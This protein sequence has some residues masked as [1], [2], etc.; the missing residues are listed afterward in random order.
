MIDLAPTTPPPAKHGQRS[1]W[2]PGWIPTRGLISAKL[3]D[4]RR[5][6]GLMLAA[7]LM[8]VA[9]PFLIF[10]I[11][12]VLHLVDPK[13]FGPGGDP[14]LFS[15]LTDLMAEFGFLFAA[16]LGTA[17]G[18]TD[19]SD[20]VFRQL[21]ITGRSRLA[22]YLARIPAGLVIVVPLVAVAFS[23]MCLVTR[24]ASP[25]PPT[26]VSVNG[27]SIPLHL[28]AAGFRAWLVEHPEAAGGA[29]GPGGP[30]TS[31][32]QVKAEIGIPT[33]YSTYT[34]QELAQTPLA[35]NEM[36]KIGLW[37][38]LDVAIGFLVGL[39]LGSLTGQRTVS[40]VAMIALEI[41]VTP[42]L[43]AHAIPY[44]L[45]G[46]RLLVGIA[47]DQL[48]PAGLGSGL[49]HRVLLGGSGALGIPLMPTWAM[50]TV[51]AGWIVVWSVLGAWRMMTRD[52]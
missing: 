40:T 46:Q 21:V 10:G 7:V 47:M 1:G 22:L 8:T 13:S 6:R 12:L 2:A 25:P 51:I 43:A 32:A 33:A 20:G 16:A 28:D 37:L 41:V 9:I 30:V 50:V 19:L 15:P 23:S 4:L 48:R 52:A 45:N 42:I 26:S 36:V 38:E 31:G 14:G 27:A 39:G 29:F 34:D 11:R 18:T 5:R 3:L 17:A 35:P 24:Y 49:G 44:F